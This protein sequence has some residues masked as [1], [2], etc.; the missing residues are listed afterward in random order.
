MDKI[1]KGCM[2]VDENELDMML[3]ALWNEIHAQTFRDER[4]NETVKLYAKLLE[5]KE[6]IQ[7]ERA[8]HE[9]QTESI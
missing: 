7:R 9:P 1:Y 8:K 5:E 6:G 3:H 4:F 2:L